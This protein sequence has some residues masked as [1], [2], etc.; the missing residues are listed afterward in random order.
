M[1]S[2]T[3]VSVT[4]KGA[5]EPA[6]KDVTLSIA[7]GERVGIVGESGSGK[8][9]LA[10][11][12]LRSLPESARVDGQISFKGEDL[13]KRSSSQFRSLR[14]VRLA[15][16]PQDP[17]AN[18]NP[19]I[20]IG[21]QLRDAI[22]AHRNVRKAACIDII[23]DALAEVGIPEP[24]IK[25]KSFPHE[26]SGGM[27]QRVLIAM[28]LINQPEFLIADEPTTALDATVQ[29]QILELLQQE[30]SSREMSLLLIT[31]DIGVVAEL[32][33]RIVVMRHGVIVEEG[34]LEEMSRNAT[35]PY[36]KQLFDAAHMEFGAGKEVA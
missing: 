21:N 25:R 22:R 28:S 26:L 13:G 19:V 24:E 3:N 8:S 10:A 2:L 11:A 20:R 36:T 15:H 4:Y 1:V 5:P 35:H 34:T 33:S 7:P 14:S 17:L 18:L 16:I 32:C 30:L 9:T 29:A 27:R 12:I 6:V 31:H 23:E